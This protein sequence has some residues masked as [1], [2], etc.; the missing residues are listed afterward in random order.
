M[1]YFSAEEA[2][3]RKAALVVARIEEKRA[4]LKRMAGRLPAIHQTWDQ[5]QTRDFKDAASNGMTIANN[6]RA[7]EASIDG[8]LRRLD[9]FYY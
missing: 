6:P 1:T 3:R 7:T 4:A 5:R 9:Q 2:Q 8:A